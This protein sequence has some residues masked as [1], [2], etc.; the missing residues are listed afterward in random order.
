MHL[1]SSSVILQPSKENSVQ[2]LRNIG[3]VLVMSS[4]LAGCGASP[5]TRLPQGNAPLQASAL[6]NRTDA[7]KTEDPEVP[8]SEVVAMI[9]VIFDGN[10]DNRV[11]PAEMYAECVK[12]SESRTLI[13]Q[14]FFVGDSNK[15]GFLTEREILQHYPRL[16]P[17]FDKLKFPF[18]PKK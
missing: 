7:K 11:T 8:V 3:L 14:I 16:E 9:V 5:A 15:D 17:L 1:V 13:N 12:T 6:K 10:A 18:W 4:L 2:I